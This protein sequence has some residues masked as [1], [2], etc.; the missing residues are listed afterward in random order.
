MKYFF[1]IQ[2]TYAP[3]CGWLRSPHGRDDFDKAFQEGLQYAKNAFLY[4]GETVGV[5][6]VLAGIGPQ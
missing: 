4:R 6:V 5:R 3:G 2:L 1:E